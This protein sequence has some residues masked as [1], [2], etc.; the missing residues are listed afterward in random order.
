MRAAGF[1]EVIVWAT[2]TQADAIRGDGE[3]QYTIIITLNLGLGLVLLKLSVWVTPEQ[4][5][6]V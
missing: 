1:R 2:P 3:G 6:H 4:A 5:A